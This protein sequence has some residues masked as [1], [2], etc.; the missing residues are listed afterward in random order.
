M[1]QREL[2]N[3]FWTKV[4]RQFN[5]RKDSLFSKWCWN[6]YKATE[7]WDGER[8]GRGIHDGEHTYTHGGVNSMYGKTNTI[9]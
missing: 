7:G 2:R 1:E 6:N 9:L 4:P 3:C 8:G 5:E